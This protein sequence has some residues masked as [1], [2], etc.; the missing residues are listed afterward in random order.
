MFAQPSDEAIAADSRMA[1][2]R[3]RVFATQAFSIHPP[4]FSTAQKAYNDESPR[5][6]GRESAVNAATIPSGDWRNHTP[7]F[8]L[9]YV[10]S[11][12]GRSRS[13]R[14]VSRRHTDRPFEFLVRSRQRAR[15]AAN[16]SCSE[17]APGLS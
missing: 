2:E 9:R 10:F 6:L 11:G 1:K 15:V 3:P 8:L 17:A 5:T 14:F 16:F 12:G 13:M 4:D 7:S